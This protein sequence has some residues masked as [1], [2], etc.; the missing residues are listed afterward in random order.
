MACVGHGICAAF[1]CALV[2]LRSPYPNLTLLLLL[3]L[4]MCVDIILDCQCHRQ[5]LTRQ[6]ASKALM[7]M[8]WLSLGLS[9]GKVASHPPLAWAD[10]SSTYYRS[11]QGD[12]EFTCPPGWET[13]PKLLKTH[14]EEV[15][16][17]GGG[18]AWLG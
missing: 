7:M 13:S 8:G 4:L 12:F 10:D 3:L 11:P 5:S 6:Q 14:L 9:S 15:R 2:I 17:S 1:F 16:G 18:Q